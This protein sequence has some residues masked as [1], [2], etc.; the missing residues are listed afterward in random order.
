VFTL[1]AAFGQL[2]TAYLLFHDLRTTAS[3]PGFVT[4]LFLGIAI[5]A[6]IL[7]GFY[8]VKS[9][10]WTLAKPEQDERIAGDPEWA[11]L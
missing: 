8:G 2:T 7:L 1:W 10:R 6:A 11:L 5:G 3:L 4:A 9:I